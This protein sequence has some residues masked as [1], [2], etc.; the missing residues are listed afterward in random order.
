M[1][2]ELEWLRS[3][4]IED[5]YTTV[6]RGG[7]RKGPRYRKPSQYE[8]VPIMEQK[9]I[10]DKKVWVW[11]D[12]HLGHKNIISFSDRPFMNVDEMDEHLIANYNEYVDPDDVCIW[13]GDIAF[14]GTEK[15]N[16]ILDRCHG[17]KILVVGN[18]DFRNGKLRNLNFD[19]THL[20]YYLDL[21]G[22]PLVFTH[23][24]MYNL[25]K[26]WI[27]IH[28]HLHINFQLDS[29]QH[30]N[31]CCEYHNYRPVEL[32]VI[33]RWAATRVESFDL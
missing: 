5:I 30:I 22:A 33:R 4:Y 29:D 12:L 21:P 24:P 6:D 20:L 7:G 8:R 16:E 13:V 9:D 32:E 17:Y 26:P 18:H 25:I 19:E 1:A 2:T 11:S 27:N 3:L 10:S 31:V 14:Y 23:F 15:T 28:G